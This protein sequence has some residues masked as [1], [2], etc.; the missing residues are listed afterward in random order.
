MAFFILHAGSMVCECELLPRSIVQPSN[1]NLGTC[2]ITVREQL[3]MRKRRKES[4]E[5]DKKRSLITSEAG[6]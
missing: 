2:A 4:K 3:R 6:V 1:Q 5:G